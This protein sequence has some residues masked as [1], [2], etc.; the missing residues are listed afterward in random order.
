MLWTCAS[1]VLGPGPSP[2]SLRIIGWM[3]RA[4][5]RSSA[6]RPSQLGRCLVERHAR[7][8]ASEPVADLRAGDA[9]GQREVHQALLGA[10]VEVALDAAALGVAERNDPGAG[11]ADLLELG[12]DLGLEA[13]VLDGHAGGRRDGADQ[14]GVVVQG[15]VVEHGGDGIPVV[16]QDGDGPVATGGRQLDRASGGVDEGVPVGQPVGELQ[17]GVVQ[18]AGEHLLEPAWRQGLAELDGEVADRRAVQSGAGQPGQECQ[19]PQHQG[20]DDDQVQRVDQRRARRE[21]PSASRTT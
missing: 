16:A 7:S 14:P 15:A 13:L 3:P 19:R 18:G 6:R 4:S 10:V 21:R 8:P 1:T 20:R 12:A 5:S 17:G 11:G 9:E 2:A